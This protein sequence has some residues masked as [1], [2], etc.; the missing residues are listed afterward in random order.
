ME[1]KQK[2]CMVCQIG[3]V[4]VII[5]ALNWGLVGL[6]NYDLVAAVLGPM[7]YSSRAVYSVIGICGLVVAVSC[8]KKIC[9]CCKEDDSS[10]KK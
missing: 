4:L 3:K 7:T 2:S 9:P 5:G 6:F 8:I 10:C 1:D